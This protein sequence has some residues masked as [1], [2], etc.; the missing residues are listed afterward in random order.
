MFITYQPQGKVDVL[1]VCTEISWRWESLQNWR[2]TKNYP[3]LLHIFKIWSRDIQ[4][5]YSNFRKSSDLIIVALF[6]FQNEV[7]GLPDYVLRVQFHFSSSV[8]YHTTPIT[9]GALY[10]HHIL[11]VP[12]ILPALLFFPSNWL[13]LKSEFQD[14]LLCSFVCFFSSL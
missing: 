7:T 11:W 9:N 10:F 2:R 5:L 14:L 6:F 1:L 3:Q 4:I 8:C 12:S 13:N